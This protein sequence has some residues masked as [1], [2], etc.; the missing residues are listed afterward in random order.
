MDTL[1]FSLI[2]WL[3]V[4]TAYDTRVELPNI[5]ITEQGNMCYSYGIQAKGKCQ[6]TKLKGFYNKNWT[7]YLN[8]GFDPNDPSDQS[9]LMHELVHYVQWHN[10]RDK[11]SCWGHLEAEAYTLQDKWQVE[12]N[13]AGNIDPFKIIMLNAACDA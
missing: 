5:V 13:I 11:G 3:N 1:L 9:R 12:H 7:I 6:T 10:G 4:N 2:T 8:A